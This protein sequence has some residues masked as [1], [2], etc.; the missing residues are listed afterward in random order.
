MTWQ[1]QALEDKSCTR[2]QSMPCLQMEEMMSGVET[3]AIKSVQLSQ[4]QEELKRSDQDYVQASSWS[5]IDMGQWGAW[6]RSS[7]AIWLLLAP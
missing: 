3:G 5:T 1:R 4:A 2:K 7:Q 6:C